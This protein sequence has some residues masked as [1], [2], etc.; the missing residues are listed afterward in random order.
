MAAALVAQRAGDAGVAE[1]AVEAVSSNEFVMKNR[2]P[3]ELLAVVRSEQARIEGD[4]EKAIV[5]LAPYMD[6]ASRFQTRVAAMEA[7]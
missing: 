5:L 4:T 6:D 1:Q 3:R 2:V 7:Y